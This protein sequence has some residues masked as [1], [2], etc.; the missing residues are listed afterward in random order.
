MVKEI[1]VK[2][3]GE[4]DWGRKVYKNLETK[5]IYKD[6]DGVLHTSTEYGEPDCPLREDLKITIVD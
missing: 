3:I 6:V 4:D 2:F 5:R 1:R